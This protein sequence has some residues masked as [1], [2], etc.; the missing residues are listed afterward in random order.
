[1]ARAQRQ[2]ALITG[3]SSGI[4]LELAKVFASEG[5]DVIIAARDK[6]K[7]ERAAQ[8]IRQSGVSPQVVTIA[9]DLTDPDGARSIYDQASQYGPIEVLVNNAGAGVWGDF[10]RET[11]LEKEMHI[12][13]LN[14]AA[15]VSLTKKFVKDMLARGS[16]KILFT[17]SIASLSPTPLLNIYSGTKAFIYHFAQALREELKDTPIVITALCPGSTDTNFF[18]AAEMENSETAKGKLA[19][20]AEVARAGFDALMAEDDHVVYPYQERIMT[21]VNKLLPDRVATRQNTVK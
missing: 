16:G 6:S 9:V 14:I 1:M 12:M 18:K 2:T 8:E 17:A 13:A 15:P 20:P 5:F 11:D 19:D 3:G 7:L 10:A 21:T 4:G